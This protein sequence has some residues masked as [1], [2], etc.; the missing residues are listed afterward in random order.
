[1]SGPAKA[2]R[3]DLA[4]V[5]VGPSYLPVLARLHEAAFPAA[6]W[7]LEALR[8]VMAVPGTG[9]WLVETG[10]G[11]AGF[12]IARLM[13]D[14]AEVLTFGVLPESRR[15]G[16]GRRLMGA[17]LA[18]ARDSGAVRVWLEVAEDNPAALA[19][20]TGAGFAEVGRRRGYYRAESGPAGR[21]G[22]VSA[23]AGSRDSA[24]D[25]L[26]LSLALDI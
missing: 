26:L 20:Y 5:E 6:P 11:P 8:S 16:L 21:A 1:M 24:K 4:P 14:E 3:S 19:L 25:A 17:L 7:S 23:R 10:Q 22:S 9:A 18:R 2:G 15:R 12:L 13:G